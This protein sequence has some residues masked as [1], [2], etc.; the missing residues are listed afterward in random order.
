VVRLAMMAGRGWRALEGK[1]ADEC[2]TQQQADEKCPFQWIQRCKLSHI[3]SFRNY[4][5]P[6]P[7][8]F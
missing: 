7:D 2:R 6:L 1:G 3:H 4:N 8:I 5:S